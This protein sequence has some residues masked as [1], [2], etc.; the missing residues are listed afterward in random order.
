M[1]DLADALRVVA[2]VFE[3]L[4]QRHHI[5]P[6]LSEVGRQIPYAERVRTETGQHRRPG[7]IADRLLTV[8]AIEDH[9]FRRQSVDVGR[10][11]MPAPVTAELDPQV[12]KGDE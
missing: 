9:S 10:V 4:R 1:K 5:R 8:R 6:V 11:N 12:I 2:G 3:E 7:R